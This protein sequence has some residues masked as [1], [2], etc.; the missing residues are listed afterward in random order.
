MKNEENEKKIKKKKNNAV[1]LRKN[2]KG[3]RSETIAETRKTQS[4]QTRFNICYVVSLNNTTRAFARGRTRMRLVGVSMRRAQSL[5]TGAIE[6]SVASQLW[7]P[8]LQHRQ[9]HSRPRCSSAPRLVAG[10]FMLR[11]NTLT[12]R[13][14]RS[15]DRTK[16]PTEPNSERSSMPYAQPRA[17]YG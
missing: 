11:K 3:N 14:S 10:S 13:R 4:P 17:T 7:Y 9:L 2:P 5:A 6:R 15:M 16:V 8:L 1:P 12:T